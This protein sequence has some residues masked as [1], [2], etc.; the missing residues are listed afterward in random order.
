MSVCAWLVLLE[1]V[2]RCPSSFVLFGCPFLCRSLRALKDVSFQRRRML[3]P[4]GTAKHLRYL[5]PM[6]ENFGTF[7]TFFIDSPSFDGHGILAKSL[8]K[9]RRVKILSNAVIID[10]IWTA[11]ER[12]G[13][14]VWFDGRDGISRNGLYVE[15]IDG[16]LTGRVKCDEM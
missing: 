12:G 11:S 5:V 16:K 13:Y 2:D 9:L 14:R 1:N 15:V 7:V 4:S 8:S 10:P 3:S 6:S